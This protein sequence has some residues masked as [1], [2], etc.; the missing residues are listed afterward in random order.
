MNPSWLSK[1][2]I[3]INTRLELNSHLWWVQLKYCRNNT[4]LFAIV[5]FCFL[6]HHLI[7]CD[8]SRSW[9]YLTHSSSSPPPR[10]LLRSPSSCGFLSPPGQIEDTGCSCNGA[11]PQTLAHLILRCPRYTATRALMR[12]ETSRISKLRIDLLLYTNM[13]ANAMA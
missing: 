13:E 2:C 8:Q 3:Y 1:I 11:P 7:A 6:L 12:Q 9:Q 4:P 10:I 5:C